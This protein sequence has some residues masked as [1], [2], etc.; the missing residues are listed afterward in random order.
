MATKLEDKR[1]SIDTVH[2]ICHDPIPIISHWKLPNNWYNADPEHWKTKA[3]KV[4]PYWWEKMWW[5]G[6][7]V[8]TWPP[9]AYFRTATQRTLPGSSQRT[10]SRIS[11]A[12]TK[13]P[14]INQ[15]QI[16]EGG[17]TISGNRVPYPGGVGGGYG[18]ITIYAP[19]IIQPRA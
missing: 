7:F 13:E 10:Q 11:P 15:I 12:W 4:R 6:V 8:C 17:T 19:M 2:L 9:P 14:N 18:I 5:R 1:T 16:C 3:E